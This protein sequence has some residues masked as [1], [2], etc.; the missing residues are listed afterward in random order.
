M[1]VD[2]PLNGRCDDGS[3]LLGLLLQVRRRTVVGHRGVEQDILALSPAI[4]WY[5]LFIRSHLKSASLLA[6]H[7]IF[8]PS[9]QLPPYLGEARRAAKPG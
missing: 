6:E 2:F 5:H 1:L 4:M 8:M 7:F 9:L 3:R